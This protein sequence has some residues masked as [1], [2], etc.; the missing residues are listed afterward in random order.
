MKLSACIGLQPNVRWSCVV[1]LVMVVVGLQ[2]QIIKQC[3]SW[4][5]KPMKEWNVILMKRHLITKSQM[6]VNNE[7]ANLFNYRAHVFHF[8]R[9]WFLQK[10]VGILQK[11]PRNWLIMRTSPAY[12][13][14]KSTFAI[15]SMHSWMISLFL[16]VCKLF[17]EVALF[18][19]YFLICM[20]LCWFLS[21]Y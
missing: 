3:K 6:H 8:P 2:Y 5:N 19:L 13:L 1:K 18:N 20:L 14:W 10:W 4:L 21:F 15:R 7:T 9:S 11:N 16:E 17:D 12:S